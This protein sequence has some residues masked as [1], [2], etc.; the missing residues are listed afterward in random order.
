[1]AEGWREQRHA[2]PA[3]VVNTSG[4][5][6]QFGDLGRS[7]SELR[8]HRDRGGCKPSNALRRPRTSSRTSVGAFAKTTRRASQSR[9]FTWSA[10]TTP[11]IAPQGA[12]R[13]QTGNP[14]PGDGAGDR[15]PRLG[16]VGARRQDQRRGWARQPPT[17]RD[18][19]RPIGGPRA[20][21]IVISAVNTAPTGIT[22]GTP[23]SP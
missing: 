16:I 6:R 4:S 17:R 15:K 19:P 7:G 20:F 1:M 8:C 10:R 12:G 14:S 5:P 9:F 2:M 13:L 18:Y 23:R 21:R 22:P 11:A 3:E